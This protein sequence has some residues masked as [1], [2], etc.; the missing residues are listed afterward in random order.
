VIDHD[1]LFKELLTTFFADFVALF[2]PDLAAH[3][4]PRSIAFLDKEVF[5]DV[6]QGERHEAD[7]IVR[8]RFRGHVSFF[9]IHVEH[10][11]QRKAE[12]PRRMF[13]YFARLHEKFSLPV[14][15]I[16]LFSHPVRQP[17]P[18]TYRMAFPHREVL[19][20]QFHAIQLSRLHWRDF[21]RRPNPVA[22]ALMSRMNLAPK[23]RP[24]VKLE[25]LRLL[26]TL[27]VDKARLRL[28]SGFIDTY[29]RLNAEETLRFRRAAD[30]V[31]AK[32][33]KAKIMEI[34]TSWKEEGLQ[35]GLLKGR[36]EGR[37]E[38]RQ[39]GLQE[40]RQEGELH[41]VLR[42]LR[43]RLASLP[44]PVEKQVCALP[45][46]DLEQLGEALLDF[47]TLS[48]LKKWLREH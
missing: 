36:Q 47:S 27:R 24:R 46:S 37:Q 33:E 12:F 6:T 38:G 30:T 28:L 39:K 16:A 20:F 32:D 44:A 48:D 2:A 34:T 9:L 1:R 26:A 5:T 18:E 25:C 10:Q 7:M 45:L 11:A 22:A 17:E 31:L 21:L 8:A 15:P 40:G 29:L 35:E 14:Y 41:L 3:L 19:R 43:R 42:L 23:D 4:D 13:R